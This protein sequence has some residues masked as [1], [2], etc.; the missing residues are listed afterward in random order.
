MPRSANTH[1]AASPSPLQSSQTLDASSGTAVTAIEMQ[2]D[3]L[4]GLPPLEGPGLGFED[5]LE[6]GNFF[7]SE[8]QRWFERFP[9]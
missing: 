9:T 6:L 4:P 8:F 7:T 2:A 3:L 1:A 5:E